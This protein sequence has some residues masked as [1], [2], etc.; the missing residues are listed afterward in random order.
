MALK[1]RL[2][3]MGRKKAPSYRLVVAE[4]TMPRDGR[5]VAS[6]G[7]Y[8]P[9]TEPLTLVVDREK[10]LFWLGQGALPTD[11]AKSLMKR[12]GVFGPAPTVTDEAAEAVRTVAKKTSTRA[13]Q[14]AA[15]VASAV[16]DAVE[17]VRETVADVAEDVREAVEEAV[18]E[19]RERVGGEDEEEA[20]P[21]EASGVAAA[22]PAA[23]SPEAAAAEQKK[24]APTSE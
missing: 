16:A 7:H 1:I 18:E 24:A 17:E 14:A 6:I 12:A 23:E 2:R 13:R 9:R 8:N 5:F 4:S 22:E 15:S 20:A 10:A 19:V 21:A 3:R 11:T